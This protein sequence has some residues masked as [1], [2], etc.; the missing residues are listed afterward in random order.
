M[1]K[2]ENWKLI[3]GFNG[4]Y[5]I[6]DHGRMK[7]FAW[8]KKDGRILRPH[9]SKY[10]Y[11]LYV[12]S[13]EGKYYTFYA[14]R[15][16]AEYFLPN[17]HNYPTVDHIKNHQKSNNHVSNL[18]WL[19]IK[20][21]IRKDQA[22]TIIC[23]HIGGEIIIAKGSRHAAE[24]TKCCRNSVLNCLKKNKINKKGWSFKIKK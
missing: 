7:S 10:G 21:N 5:L 23:K 14:H 2:P 1:K 11:H 3:Q 15:I 18:Q 13:Y 20:D 17:P 8:N 9:Q 6:S 22:E 4:R 12:I 24:L 16:C 19:P